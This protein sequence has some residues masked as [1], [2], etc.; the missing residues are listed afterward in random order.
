MDR[1]GGGTGGDGGYPDT[2]FAKK[3]ETE[4]PCR[5]RMNPRSLEKLWLWHT[6]FSLT[7][8][9]GADCTSKTRLPCNPHTLCLDFSGWWLLGLL[10]SFD[11]FLHSP[12]PLSRPRDNLPPSRR[13]FGR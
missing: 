2:N 6:L 4:R 8:C 10:P 11:S 13:S 12:S 5:S 7:L 3:E 9:K 1:E